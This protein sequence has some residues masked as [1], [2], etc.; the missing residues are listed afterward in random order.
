MPYYRLSRVEQDTVI[1]FNA[2]DDLADI[3]TANPVTLRK[4]AKLHKEFPEI[5]KLV[6]QDDN[7]PSAAYQFPKKLL[8]FAKPVTLSEQQ[9]ERLAKSGFQRFSPHKR[10]E[11]SNKQGEDR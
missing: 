11:N 6:R 10:A 9:R 7:W 8:R 3:D 2:E 5:Y 4:L 1:T